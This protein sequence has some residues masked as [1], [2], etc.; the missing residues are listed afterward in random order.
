MYGPN[1]YDVLD[2]SQRPTVESMIGLTVQQRYV[3][4]NVCRGIKS[5]QRQLDEYKEV[6]ERFLD[7]N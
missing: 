7:Y 4:I 2:P 3:I 6:L 1:S 5:M